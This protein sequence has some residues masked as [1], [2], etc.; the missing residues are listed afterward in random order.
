MLS[1]YNLLSISLPLLPI[2]DP[3]KAHVILLCRCEM[4][5][6]RMLGL[7]KLDKG[8]FMSRILGARRT[9]T[10]LRDNS[11]LTR[12]RRV[13]I[14]LRIGRYVIL[15]AIVFVAVVVWILSLMALMSTV[16]LLATIPLGKAL[17]FAIGVPA[18]L[19]YIWGSG[20]FV[21]SDWFLDSISSP[22]QKWAD[23]ASSESV[24]SERAGI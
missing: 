24:K 10:I 2:L 6:F 23:G 16:T 20:M 19:G 13:A 3:L 7:E 5:L 4:V 12:I 11:S 8:K 14:M 21:T 9:G 1:I 22:L 17:V 15:G 18:G